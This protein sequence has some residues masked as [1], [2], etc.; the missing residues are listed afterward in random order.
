MQFVGI[1]LH[2]N[3]FTCCYRD[4]EQKADGKDGKR[5]E[6]F[7]LSSFGMAR[8]YKTLTPNTYVLLEATITTFCFARTLQPVVKEVIVANTYELK[9]ISLGRNKTD[10]IDEDKLCR[11]V[12]MQVLSGEKAI[13]PV[14]I[15]PAEIQEL[16]GLF[17]TY[18]LLKKQCTQYKNRIH[19]LVKEKLYGYS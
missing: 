15:P 17:S 8:F 19:S 6:T 1:D 4:D 10:K 7:E 2:T 16:R 18:R 11:I 3:R 9:Q 14:T 12:K 13:S 5:I